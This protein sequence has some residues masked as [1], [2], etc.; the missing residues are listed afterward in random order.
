MKERKDG[1]E[2]GISIITEKEKALKPIFPKDVKFF[3]EIESYHH[4]EPEDICYLDVSGFSDAD[5][6]KAI[7][8]LKKNCKNAPWGVIDPKGSIK[9]PALLFFEGASDYLRPQLF[10]E[11]KAL[12]SKRLKIAHQWRTA[13]SGKTGETAAPDE[14]IIAKSNFPK[15]GIKLPPPSLFPGWKNMKAGRTMP[16]YLLFC[17]LQGKNPL[18]ARLGEKAYDLLQQRL[19]AYLFKNFKDGDGLV[20]LDS[21]HDFLFLLPP[22]AQHVQAAITACIRMLVSAPLIAMEILGLTMPAN[23]VFA[24]HYGP[25]TYSPPGKTGT[26]IS[27]A[28]NYIFH[29]GRKKAKLGCL[30]ISDQLPDDSVPKV[31]E[32]CFVCTGEYEGHKIWH[33]KKFGYLKPWL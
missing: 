4:P 13:L 20:W 16:F 7:D 10:K 17:S 9:D 29:L 12:D 6:K 1:V 11:T 25:I 5:I 32:D 26:V 21:G 28:V 27:D 19:L 14:K 3:K 33:T 8:R 23:F 2:M 22:K 31:L 30:T 24:L 18:N 15:S